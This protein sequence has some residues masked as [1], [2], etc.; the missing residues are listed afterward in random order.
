MIYIGLQNG[1]LTVIEKIGNNDSQHMLWRCKCECGK[2]TIVSSSNM[3][4]TRSCGCSKHKKPPNWS[5]YGKLN[6]A[7]V[8]ALKYGAKKRRINYDND[9]DAKYLYDMY[10][11]QN[12]KCA[13]TGISI[14]LTTE[15]SVDRIDSTQGYIKNNIW[16]VKKDINKMKL[17]FPLNLF[18][19]LCEKVVANKENI[20]NG[21]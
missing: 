4:R 20:R 3:R 9:I 17:D 6:G 21:R 14:D 12:G 11:R 19:E 13:I 15:A 10:I 5:G 8:S 1:L 2:N 18:I 7:Y 16:W